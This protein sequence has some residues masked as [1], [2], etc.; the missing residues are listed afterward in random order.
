MHVFESFWAISTFWA[1]IICALLPAC[2]RQ[3]FDEKQ[4]EQDQAVA[5]AENEIEFLRLQRQSLEEAL[6]IVE[7][8]HA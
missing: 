7:Q 6:T 4:K 8:E 5:K 1:N 3:T 2:N